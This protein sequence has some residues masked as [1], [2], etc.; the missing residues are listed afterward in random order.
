MYKKV[1][2][3]C[4]TFSVNNSE[5]NTVIDKVIAVVQAFGS[6]CLNRV[7]TRDGAR[8]NRRSCIKAL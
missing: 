8:K 3:S 2:G 5:Y 6:P 7:G 4:D 1:F